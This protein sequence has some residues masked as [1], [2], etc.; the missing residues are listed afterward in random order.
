MVGRPPIHNETRLARWLKLTGRTRTSFAA[1]LGVPMPT[2]AHTVGG[3]HPRPDLGR[4]IAAAT[5][6]AVTF[7]DL[8]PAKESAA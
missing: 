6:G 8:Y 5:S 4:K 7:E 3:R 2:I 1:E